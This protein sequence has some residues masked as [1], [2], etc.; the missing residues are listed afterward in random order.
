MPDTPLY[1]TT[2][3]YLLS[4]IARVQAVGSA[5]TD[6]TGGS[7]TRTLFEG[8]AAQ[9]STHS[10]VA[11]Q[12]RRDSFLAT[13]TEDA[14][15]RK[16][17][18]SQVVRKP[19]VAAS[20]TVRLTRQATGTAVTIPA[21]FG[22]LAT[23]PTPGS[24]TISFLTTADAVFGT[25]DLSIVV[26]AVAATG[27]TLGNIAANTKLLPINPV[28][29]FA[30]D[31]GFKAETTF[32]GGVEQ[33]TDDALRARV[34][35]EVQGRV[36]GTD[37]AFLAAALRVPGVESAAVLRPLDVRADGSTVPVPN[38][39]VYY[40]GAASL[41]SAVAS[42]VGN[43]RT[44]G[45]NAI[46]AAAAAQGVIVNLTVFCNAGTDT[47]ALAAAVRDAVKA[48]ID[49]AG[50]G[51]TTFSSDVVRAVQAVPGVVSQTIPYSDL[52]KDTASAGTFG[53]LVPG[54]NK[55]SDVPDANVTVAVSVLP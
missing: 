36:K 50:V 39:E 46:S 45:Q 3:D 48:A 16:A 31:G 1:K 22:E 29:G 40:E 14:L 5:L 21:G 17:A 27:G 41:A 55:F 20:G 8:L 35:L 11:D 23:Q 38:V 37:A 47:A 52:R 54:S 12:L 44:S 28:L 49:A 51:G 33:E 10:L 32:T 53:N 19:A 4:A 6:F 24:P 15:D 26:P 9:L 43:A 2:D 7:I 42:E 18:D 13:A 25:T 34:P 30:S